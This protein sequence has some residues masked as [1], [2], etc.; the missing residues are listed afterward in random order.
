VW[1]LHA[2]GRQAIDDGHAVATRGGVSHRLALSML[3]RGTTALYSVELLFS[4]GLETDAMSALRI[5]AELLIDYEWIWKTDRDDRIR[6]F[7][8]HI[9][10]IN[11]R[12]LIHWVNPPGQPVNIALAEKRFAQ[13]DP[14]QRPPGVETAEKYMQ[15]IEAEYQR[16][17]TSYDER[18][19]WAGISTRRRAQEVG[20]AETY[21]LQF[22]LGSEATHS[23]AAD[24]PCQSRI[25]GQQ[26][27][28]GRV[29]EISSAVTCYQA[30]RV[31]VPEILTDEFRKL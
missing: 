10:I 23:G 3:S 14:A 4:A 8:E 27:A 17:R 16:V 6:L 2:L 9:M 28:P 7:V 1:R 20:L 24:G 18:K 25:F 29:S 22:T 31:W 30:R 12:R 19:S 21:D 11:R 5:I 26:S 15:W 13:I